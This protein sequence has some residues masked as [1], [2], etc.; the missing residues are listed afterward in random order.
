L[1]LSISLTKTSGNG[2]SQLSKDLE[3]LKKERFKLTAIMEI[4][5]D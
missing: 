3:E 4:M 5:R 2:N 1:S